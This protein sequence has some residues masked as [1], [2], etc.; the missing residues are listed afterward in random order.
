MSGRR[1]ETFGLVEWFRAGEY[2]R[3]EASPERL[4]QVGCD[5]LRSHLSWAEYHDEG[6]QAWYDWLL[7]RLAAEVE[8]LPCIHYTPPS[9]SETGRSNGPPRDLGAYADFVDHVLDRYGAH[10]RT[11]ELWNEP[12]NL[13]D[14]DW[15]VDTDWLKFCTMVG[16]A[17]YWARKRGQRVVLGGPCPNDLN[18]LN[19]MGERGVL[20]E[21]DALGLH[22]FPG[23]WDAENVTW[24]GWPDLIRSVRQVLQRHNDKAEIWITE[25]GYSSWRLDWRNHVSR[26]V[27]AL[28]A[29]A[30][31][32]YWYALQDL[33]D[34]VKIQE[35]HR[36][37][38]RHYHL[39]LYD[40]RGRAKPLA[41]L[42][43]AGGAG[44]VRAAAAPPPGAPAIKKIRPVLITGGAGFIGCNLAS[45]LASEGES[46]V[47]LDSFARPGVERNAAWLKRQHGGRISTVLGDLR[48]HDALAE[49]CQDATAV[50]HF[51]AQVAVT[52]SLDDPLDDFDVN[53]RGTLLLLEALRRRPQPAPLIFASTNKVYGDLGRLALVE[54]SDSYQPAS[55]ATAKWGIDETQPLAFSTPY[56]CSKG[57][58]DQYVC[59]YAHSYGVP[60][61]VLRMSCVYGPR[62]FGTEDQGWVAHFLIRALNG[63]P[64]TVYGNGKQVRDV[65]FVD[66]AVDAYVA[67]WKQVHALERRAFNLGGGA[68]NAISLLQLLRLIRSEVNPEVA[69][70]FQ[71]WRQGDQRY[72]VSDVRLIRSTLG[73]AA[74]LHWREGIRRLLAWLGEEHAETGCPP[75]RTATRPAL[76]KVKS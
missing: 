60:T 9:L 51:A 45:R 23:T 59:D 17:A 12:N 66:D 74:P 18:W 73:L 3:V 56:G 27:D 4:R 25:T 70:D 62:Q 47:V 54:N 53:L 49:A 44:A 20:G 5:A 58:A 24:E 50:F 21:I 48:D 32:V 37:D 31:R 30:E 35:G 40:K 34:N 36:F 11:V 2:E 52:S 72:Y 68:S 75:Q 1:K 38:E 46:V 42:L 13:L 15:R 33:A 26:F 67:A 64:I 8:L 14:W 55:A 76:A 43:I 41:R 39:G 65:L 7:P 71:P 19:L 22:G 29:P 16:A 57:A 10:F 69:V 6:G 63:E 28:D 61:A